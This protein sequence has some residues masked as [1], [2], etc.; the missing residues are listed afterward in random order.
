MS[1]S[2]GPIFGNMDLEFKANLS[3]L[4]AKD[5]CYCC[6]GHP[7]QVYKVPNDFFGNNEMT[8]E[9]WNQRN[10][11]MTFTCQVLEVYQI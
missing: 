4:N 6:T 11:R 2:Y 7:K 10:D 3:T 8:G 1:G 9:G 5:G